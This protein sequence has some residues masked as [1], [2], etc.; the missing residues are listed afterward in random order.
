MRRI[1]PLLLIFFLLFTGARGGIS[2]GGGA[3]NPGIQ[4]PWRFGILSDTHCGW[5]F[6]QCGGVGNTVPLRACVD[7]L[8][9]LHVDFCIL[10]GDW[11]GGHVMVN[12][13]AQV[14]SLYAAMLN[15]VTFPVFPV[16]GNHE[17]IDPDTLLGGNPYA[18]AIARFPQYFVGRNY[19]L[20][21]WK[22]VRFVA[23]QTNVDY[24]VGDPEDYRVN[25]P[26]YGGSVPSYDWDGL[27]ASGGAERTFLTGALSGRPG[28]HWL[29]FGGH[30]GI[31][32]S[33]ANNATRHNYNAGRAGRY[34][35]QAEDALATGERGLIISGDQHIPVWLTKAIADSAIVGATA[36]G[37]Y[38]MI[39]ASGSGA[40]VA[41][42]TE[43]FG[44]SGLSAFVYY[45]QTTRNRGRTS[46]GW[47]ESM[48]VANDRGFPCEF[49]WTLC[50][51]YGDVIKLEFFR[52]YTAASAGS[53]GYPGAN[54]HRLISVHTLS[55]DVG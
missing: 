4:Y 16:L 30:R 48:T 47:L 45:D 12:H 20:Q 19:Y 33:S 43:V 22:N 6:G 40:R 49:T 26:T 23:M 42:S 25:N 2:R 39:V 34:V 7:T 46:A 54:R 53:T 41:D 13:A 14:E 21:D 5:G 1:W 50:T 51:V 32:G 38:H 37:F 10:N 3:S 44:G 8:N 11:A 27:H 29:V 35:K 28:S 9:S 24:D 18:S 36:K 52:T 17:A 55:R 15:R 31:Y